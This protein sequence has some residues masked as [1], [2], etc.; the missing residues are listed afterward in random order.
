V[1]G[2]TARCIITGLGVG[3]LALLVLA[4]AP[5]GDRSLAPAALVL[6]AALAL[7]AA[8][9]ALTSAH[10][11][12]ARVF[13]G[14]GGGQKLADAVARLLDR[15]PGEALVYELAASL[16]RLTGAELARVRV[17]P[18]EEGGVA[19]ER[20]VCA[21][22]DATAVLAAL[23]TVEPPLRDPSMQ[24]RSLPL[25]GGVR[26]WLHLRLDAEA[27]GGGAR[28]DLVAAPGGGFAPS[29]AALGAL[30]TRLAAARFNEVA[31]AARLDRAEAM[32]ADR[33]AEIETILNSISEA[34]FT[35]D[36][37]WRFTFLNARAEEVLRCSA[38]ELIGRN[39][40][41][42]FPEAV[43]TE[44]EPAYRRAMRERVEVAVECFYAPLDA[45][46]SIRALPRGDG[47][48][49]YFRDVSER[50]VA[51][52]QLRQA[53][54]M[55]ALGQLT[56]GIAHDF[57]NLLT[58]VMG[59]LEMVADAAE[60]GDDDRHSLEVALHASEQAARLTAQL[61]AFARRQ[62]L[63]PRDLDV[64]DLMQDWLELL[65]HTLGP[66]VAVQTLV[67]GG[68]APIH[69]DPTQLQNA[70]LNLALN[71]RD[72]MG[73]QGRL[74]IEA[75]DRTLEPGWCRAHAP[76]LAP[77]RYVR[78]SVADTGPG[79]P[80]EVR[81]R[82][83]D[84]FFTTK[85]GGDGSGLGL[86]MVYGFAKQSEGHVS[87]YSEPGLGT[88]VA[89]YLPAAVAEVAANENAVAAESPPGGNE[90]V[91]VVEDEAEVR[92]FLVRVLARLGYDVV[93]AVDA[94]AAADTLADPSLE[95]LVSDIGLPG[96]V[97]GLE[98]AR[99]AL[100]ERDDLA[101]VLISGYAAAALTAEQMAPARAVVMQ[102]PLHIAE[103]A[104]AVREALANV[105]AAPA[106]RPQ[107]GTRV[108]RP[109][110]Q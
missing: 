86:A 51:D 28:I 94:A 39:L 110:G 93:A 33:A 4:P 84:P 40:W 5:L 7:A 52:A 108:N 45:W 38:A 74:T 83:F 41:E 105:A 73:G 82:A 26:P 64:R 8:L 106:T 95:V 25:A 54:K 24:E 91:L 11:R 87:L 48:I 100:E 56:G 6:A 20:V 50:V 77:G 47:L 13:R 10:R 53:Q 75:A 2:L 9:L 69:V 55:E 67:E 18:V 97:N 1:S 16:R 101:V 19:D 57:N 46:F 29:A 37:A 34:V 88:T 43:A 35:L 98:L 27:G 107:P 99:R 61:L 62:P 3:V 90:R 65:K 68:L 23:D 92:T 109:S 85:G 80:P 76:G 96:G 70:V 36:G 89:L 60:L 32:A 49:V 17:A 72:A 66:G 104:R 42:A 31:R 63:A 14:E 44:I 79:M 71:A 59:N 21:A 15:R 12:C 58:V 81:E 78:L 103:L 22:D 102:K 30:L